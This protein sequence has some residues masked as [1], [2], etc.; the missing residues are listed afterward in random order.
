[1]DYIYSI[2]VVRGQAAPEI[3]YLSSDYEKSIIAFYELCSTDFSVNWIEFNKFPADQVFT[4][5]S[6]ARNIGSKVKM[7]KSSK[8]R[9]KFKSLDEL[10]K[11]YL[12]CKRNQS[13][14]EI[15]G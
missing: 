8:Y 12:S 14:E 11:V 4:D 2:S 6:A 15:L 5:K 3:L 9:I 10:K 13:L 7:T 1:M